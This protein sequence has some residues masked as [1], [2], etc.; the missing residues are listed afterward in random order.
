MRWLRDFRLVGGGWGVGGRIEDGCCVAGDSGVSKEVVRV[1]ERC[2][3]GRRVYIGGVDRQ[4]GWGRCIEG[5]ICETE[6]VGRS[7][8]AAMGKW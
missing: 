1:R 4:K 8:V 5:G 2:C 6:R 7:A 3:R